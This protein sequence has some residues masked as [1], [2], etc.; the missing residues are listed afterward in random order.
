MSEL[1]YKQRWKMGTQ[2]QTTHYFF[3]KDLD[4]CNITLW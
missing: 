1:L 2:D 4:C 3:G